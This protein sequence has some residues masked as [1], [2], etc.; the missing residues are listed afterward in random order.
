M[1]IKIKLFINMKQVTK[2]IS[3][4]AVNNCIQEY[5][6]SRKKIAVG[7][8]IYSIE[9]CN[10]EITATQNR[11]IYNSFSILLQS[12]Y[13]LAL[14]KLN[15]EIAKNSFPANN[16]AYNQFLKEK[17]L[18]KSFNAL[19]QYQIHIKAFKTRLEEAGKVNYFVLIENGLKELNISPYDYH[20]VKNFIKQIF[21]D[22]ETIEGYTKTFVPPVVYS[23][24]H[25]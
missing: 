5:Q 12:H 22:E 23:K 25:K 20:Q 9:Q 4:E 8:V 18:N 6:E 14:A 19:G 16:Y 3:K 1:L 2:T 21:Q 13:P 7:D 24:E 10:T 11:G 17:F 15:K